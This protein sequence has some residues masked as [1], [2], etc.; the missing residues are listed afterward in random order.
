MTTPTG[1]GSNLGTAYGK[2]RVDYES[3]G[4]S[5]AV[6]DVEALQSTLVGADAAMAKSGKTAATTQAQINHFAAQ[7]QTAKNQVEQFSKAADI[8]QKR[9]D[10]MAKRGVKGQQLIDAKGMAAQTKSDVDKAKNVLADWQRYVNSIHPTLHAPK[11]DIAGTR[12]A[13]NQMRSA[14]QSSLGGA[15]G[16]GL[17]A[18]G[19]GGGSAGLLSK[20][21][22]FG[23]G[24]G[25]ASAGM[26]LGK[27]AAGGMAAG[28]TAG[29][30][31]IATAATAVLGAAAA[32]IGY[33]LTKGFQRLTSLDEAAAKL[34][35]LGKSTE[36]IEAI[37]KS[38]LA[39]VDKT[40]FGLDEAFATAAAAIATGIKPGEELTNY[41]KMVADNAALAGMSMQEMG[42]IFGKVASTGKLQGD[43]MNIFMERNIDVVGNL[44]KELNKPRAAVKQ[45]VTDGKVDWETF[46]RA[47]NANAGAAVTMGNS[48][49]GSFKNLRASISR[50]GAALLAP[51]FGEAT[52]EAG[53]FAKGIQWVTAQ[54]KKLEDWLGNNK[55]TL[56]NFWAE[57][58]LGAIGF[59]ETV[60][61]V[62]GKAMQGF[63]GITDFLADALGAMARI[64]EIGGTITGDQNA[65]DEAKGFRD[66]A[67]GLRKFGETVDEFGSKTES[68]TDI[69][70]K[71]RVAV[72]G[73]RDDSIK[74]ANSTKTL[75]E[76]E[77]DSAAK[78]TTLTE[79]LDALGEKTDGVEK[80]LTGTNEQ[81]EEFIKKLEKKKAP[82][83]LIA[84]L[85]TLR[86][87]FVNGGRQAKT[88][89]DAV[90]DFGDAS[91]SADDRASKFISS[92]QGL[93]LLPGGDK[94]RDYNKALDEM[95][96]YDSDLIDLTDTLGNSLINM[97]GTLNTSM[98]NGATLQEQISG[99]RQEM[100]GLVAS[101]EATPDEA[102]NRTAEGLRILLSRAG[103]TG[104]EA[105]KVIQKYL[106]TPQSMAEALKKNTEGALGA[107]GMNPLQVD[108]A[109]KLITQADDILNQIVGP[110][111]QLH[112]PTVL[113][114]K[115]P[116]GP[117]GQPVAPDTQTVPVGT[118]LTPPAPPSAPKQPVAA[119]VGVSP[120][121]SRE[122]D[123][124]GSTPITTATLDK[125]I[126][127]QADKKFAEKSWWDRLLSSPDYSFGGA[128]PTTVDPGGLKKLTDDPNLTK[129]LIGQHKELSNLTP[130]IDDAKKS[131]KSLAE[132]FAEGIDSGQDDVIRSIINLAAIAG[133]GLGHSPAKYGPLSGKGW[134]YFRGQ[135][136]TTAYAEGIQSQSNAAQLAV[137][138]TLQTA[139]LP[140]GEQIERLVGDLQQFSDFGKHLL[141]FGTQLL[142]IGFGAA[143]LANTL[144]GGKLFPKSYEKDTEA[145]A[146]KGSALAPWNPRGGG[147][148]GAGTPSPQTPSNIDTSKSKL[149]D[150]GS[151]SSIQSAK[152]SA[153]ILTQMFPG[154]ASIG[155]S[156][157]RPPGTPQ[158]HTEGRALDVGIGE[159][160][161]ANQKVGD[162]INKYVRDNAEALGVVSTIWRD[163][164]KDFKGNTSPVGGHQNHV[165]ID[166]APGSK[167]DFTGL[168]IP[169]VTT[170]GGQG[171]TPSPAP[172][173][174]QKTAAQPVTGV[175][176]KDLGGGFYQEKGQ[177]GA[178]PRTFRKIGDK[179]YDAS[180]IAL[181]PGATNAPELL[182][183]G[184]PVARIQPP[185]AQTTTTTTPSTQPKGGDAV[186]AAIIAEG[187][188]RGWSQEQILAALG[189]AN[190]ETGYGTNPRTNVVQNQNGTAGITG[191]FQQ[192]MSYRKYGN[193]QDVNNA[194]NG[195]MTEFE[196]RGRGLQDPNPWR[197]A[198]SDV[199]IPAAA[200]AGG[201]NDATG[202]Y[203]QGRQRE[204]ALATYNRLAGTA[205]AP[206]V[207]VTVTGDAASDLSQIA[208]NTDAFSTALDPLGLPE[209]LRNIASTDSMLA[210]A[211]AASTGQK[212]ITGEEAVPLLQ[213]LDGLI[214]DQN[215]ANTPQ[216]K[217]M[218]QGLESIRGSILSDQGLKEGPTGLEKGEQ[219]ASGLS[220]IASDIFGVFD[221]T[222]KTISATK[223]ITGTLVRGIENTGD[224]FGEGGLI[225]NFQQYI[226]LAAKIFQTAGDITSFAGSF[227]GGSDFGGVAAAG[228]AMALIGQALQAINTGIDLAQEGYTIVTKY[229]GRFLTN[230]L[231]FPGATDMKFLLDEATGQ[232]QAYTS[233]N[234]QLKHTFNTLPRELGKE[235]PGRPAP[236]NNLYV[237]QGPG[238]D[239][240]DTMD[241]AM[242]TV[243]SSGVGAFGYASTGSQG[244]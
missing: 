140:F 70:N 141:D 89:A 171:P 239:P 125:K 105:D 99:I 146:L 217:L 83:D 162:A 119:T 195:F 163:Q 61:H 94:L 232:V 227:T 236:T 153:A 40:S 130:V 80:S 226:T 199:Q 104:P 68:S 58:A 215:Q 74:A 158:H 235:Y 41:L 4:V 35:A 34:K 177:K 92:L 81:F 200:G 43:E 231:G 77:E 233:D 28:I 111:G 93:G 147:L 118:G 228:Q 24:A 59:A 19:G 18:G 224:I 15:G 170:T 139:T 167:V 114:I 106:P 122:P 49:T 42:Y 211:V 197:H 107:A 9:A 36:E 62:V 75:T 86:E 182:P 169:G 216:S 138:G 76:N 201:Y 209:S 126:K 64:D 110:D 20:L 32:G 44:A 186:A 117:D 108:S 238:Q 148:P 202:A 185:P 27:L 172:S 87:Q 244:W 205:G 96:K 25:L 218:A 142:D 189:V 5:K 240:R 3:S 181:A 82:Q 154:I 2:V 79:A 90:R 149:V 213:H 212:T 16:G 198:V 180:D 56:I 188:R 243:R 173:A 12:A 168:G 128:G 47:M 144:S 31:G 159:I 241:D 132:A 98:K 193:P 46:Q 120:S 214:T 13:V 223:D 112:V 165:H 109:L 160:T 137:S 230:W 48:I 22:G 84:T 101:G 78:T 194:I 115:N 7:M 121:G 23:S 69:W 71:A 164:W 152:E 116:V 54:L 155:G 102:F 225:D 234:P 203:L 242:F 204:Q 178:V 175:Q 52:G 179:F 17:G 127:E 21:M 26:S 65:K 10:A 33:T 208:G 55:A 237:F 206:A 156:S 210:D 143:G 91:Q 60:T 220:G 66:T 191:V 100:V 161:A 184:L 50:I 176:M 135:T 221:E 166:F 14:A 29:A 37:S 103:I 45:L 113:D 183:S 196:K 73:W 190:Q 136:F 11:A 124:P 8:A 38:A 30:V 123:K 187:K 229:L 157:D 53:T 39:A 150:S 57:A 1:G 192:D 222:L 85:Q 6:K 151:R 95:T 207:P 97:D 133:D 72:R 67:K 129:L 145:K 219:I 63:K 51:L 88:F 174:G 131:G 134:T